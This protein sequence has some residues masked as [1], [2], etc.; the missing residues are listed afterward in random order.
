MAAP[1]P[2]FEAILFDLDGTLVEHDRP[3]DEVFASAFDSVGVDPFC[4]WKQFTEAARDVHDAATTR[5]FYRQ[6]YRIAAERH[7]GP[8]SA[9]PDLATAY[10]DGIDH[11]AV[12]LRPGAEQAL[13]LARESHHVGLVTNG[14]RETQATKLEAVG[15]HDAFETAVFAGGQGHSK[16]HPQP[17]HTAV[18]DLDVA[19]SG[20]Y[21]VG[22]SLAHDVVGAKRAGLG[23][24]WYPHHH[25]ETDD[26]AEFEHR[27]D[28]TFETL[29]DI[30]TVLAGN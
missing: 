13:D 6:T 17:F 18:D 21:Y 11:T 3:Y 25:D 14:D 4:D 5:E 27:P 8:V 30:E 23:A 22:N 26:P 12:S 10:D 24:G 7:D 15:L 16:P 2:G 9:V 1:S 20:A 28:H 29:H 19:T